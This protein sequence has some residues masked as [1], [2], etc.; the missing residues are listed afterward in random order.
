[1]ESGKTSKIVSQRICG[2]YRATQVLAY[3][4]LTPHLR[5]L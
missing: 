1:M 5:Q 3:F 4:A 2:M